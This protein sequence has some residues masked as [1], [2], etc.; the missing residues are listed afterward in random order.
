[1][2]TLHHTRSTLPS[3]WILLAAALCWC[4]APCCAMYRVESV[5]RKIDDGTLLLTDKLSGRAILRPTSA[6]RTT[7]E[8][9]FKGYT[10]K[11]N[12]NYKWILTDKP[13]T[14]NERVAWLYGPA[15]F[16][17]KHGATQS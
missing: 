13:G 4:V 1:M 12:G 8:T 9:E 3:P 2:G 17:N 6:D 5:I 15:D 10:L 16:F 11:Y 7:F 14:K